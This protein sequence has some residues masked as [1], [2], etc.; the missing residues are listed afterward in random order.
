MFVP[1]LIEI[2]LLDL[3]SLEGPNTREI[4]TEWNMHCNIS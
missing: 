3:K 1:S 4:I 2:S